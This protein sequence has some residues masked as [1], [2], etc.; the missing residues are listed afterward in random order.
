MSRVAKVLVEMS[1]DKE[2]D[3]SYS[4]RIKVKEGMRVLV[5]FNRRK[6]M[7]V[8]VETVSKSQ[9]KRIKPIIDVL[10]SEVLLNSEH[11]RFAET[12]SKFYPYGKGTF[13]FMMIPPYLRKANKSDLKGD[14]DL[15]SQSYG[16]GSTKKGHSPLFIK[17]D[18]FLN[19]YKIWEKIVKEK[20]KEGS[21]LIC[22]PQLTYL[23]SA[24]KIIEKDFPSQIKVIHSQE[25]EKDLFCNWGETR[26]NALILG[27][28]AAIFY[29]PSDLKLIVV[30]EENSPYYFQEEKPYHN[31]SDVASVLSRVKGVDLILSGDYPSLDTYWRI[32]EKQT[33]L[34][35]QSSGDRNIKVINMS[36]FNKNKIINP[37]LIELLKKAIQDNK[38]ALILWNR[39]GFARVVCSSCGYIFK[40]KHCSSPLRAPSKKEVGVCHYC[41][42]EVIL[43]SICS[44]CNSGYLRSKGFG[45]QRIGS[46]LKK[47]FP[48]AKINDSLDFSENAQITLFTSQIL[49]YI[50]ESQKFDKGFVLD[51]D[52]ALYQTDYEATFK[53]FLYLK[54]LSIL[55]KDSLYVFTHHKK[56]YLF[57]HLNE[58]WKNF[59]ESEL[60][61]REK[62]NFPPF[63]LIVKITFRAKNEK[64]L[65]KKINELHNRLKVK[66]KEIYGPFEEKPYK[67][68]DKFRCSI[69]LKIKKDS[70]SREFI[71]EEIKGFRSPSIQLAVS[72]R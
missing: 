12:L 49:S 21:V 53:T 3:Y 41:R 57:K 29:Y 30:E 43:P 62:S 69:I 31:L 55:I 14:S 15:F 56:Y 24:K 72:I 65:L 10:D 42:R 8:V 6:R 27:T 18:I 28:R 20:L 11:M 37:I 5:D 58:N 9:L 16:G 40:C 51:A 13:L 46:V 59:Y 1:L 71:K 63:G 61:F 25:K 22:F 23:E 39:K 48:E 34:F 68:R 7:G 44:Q 2:F 19:R 4:D 38:K 47:I 70:S 26:R 32:K 67:L 17:A 50:Y 36:E 54:K 52:L 35:D 60:Q 33:K 45:V 64:N 66:S